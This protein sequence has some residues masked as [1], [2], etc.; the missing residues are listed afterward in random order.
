MEPSTRLTAKDEPEEPSVGSITYWSVNSHSRIRVYSFCTESALSIIIE[1]PT[2]C[3]KRTP[4][5]PINNSNYIHNQSLNIQISI[6][7]INRNNNSNFKS[8]KSFKSRLIGSKRNRKTSFPLKQL[9]EVC[10][11]NFL[12]LKKTKK[13]VRKKD[14]PGLQ[15]R[16]IERKLRS[17]FEL[18]RET[19]SMGL[20]LQGN[21]R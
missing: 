8:F 13:R 10:Y 6:Y 15:D 17:K 4:F 11:R 12:A 21:V 9:R 16:R 7:R 3:K 5:I 18:V 2:N 20:Q 19:W 1:S 14:V